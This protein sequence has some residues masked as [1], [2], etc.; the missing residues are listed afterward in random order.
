ME[1]KIVKEKKID[2]LALF[3]SFIN[4]APEEL[5]QEEVILNNSTLS[6]T[7]KEELIKSLKNSDRIMDKL[8]KTSYKTLNLKVETS[9]L[10]LNTEKNV[11]D[12]KE[13]VEEIGEEK[14]LY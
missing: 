4:P 14:E 5:S 10:K 1:N 2:I 8:F 3:K 11:L 6:S 13:K 12:P 7:Q 9:N